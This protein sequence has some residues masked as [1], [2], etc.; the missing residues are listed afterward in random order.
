MEFDSIY[1]YL[2]SVFTEKTHPTE[3]EIIEAKKRYYR[4]WHREY[5]RRRR[6]YRKE[7]TL[8]FAPDVLKRIKAQKGKESVSKYLYD[9]VFDA[10]NNGGKP[11][12]DPEQLTVIHQKLMQLMALLE[13]QG[14]SPQIEEILDRI[15][16]LELQ[17]SKLI[18]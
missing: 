16:E 11:S 3:A 7:F 14:E 13:E 6:K 18:Q 4:L 17:F 1:D 2:D 5:N 10:L 15:E 9:A 8:G 12:Y